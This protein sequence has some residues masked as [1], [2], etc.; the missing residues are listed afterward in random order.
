MTVP[1][2]P[3]SGKL[4]AGGDVDA[5]ARRSLLVGGG[6]QVGIGRGR[7]DDLIH[8]VGH[9]G[10]HVRHGDGARS[11]A[12]DLSIVAA[13]RSERT[14]RLNS[15]R[16]RRRQPR[17]GLRDRGLSHQTQVE[18]PARRLQALAERVFVVGAVA[19]R[20]FGADQVEIGRRRAQ[21]DI[22]LDGDEASAPGPNLLLGLPDPRSIGKIVYRLFHLKV[23]HDGRTVG[24]RELGVRGPRRIFLPGQVLDVA[25]T[26]HHVSLVDARTTGL[27]RPV[28][29][30]EPAPFARPATWDWSRKRWPWPRRACPPAP[31][32][33]RTAPRRAR[34]QD[35]HGHVRASGS[36]RPQPG[37]AS[38]A[39]KGAEVGASRDRPWRRQ[40]FGIGRSTSIA[41]AWHRSIVA[42]LGTLFMAQRL[43]RIE[44]RCAPGRVESEHDSDGDAEADRQK[45]GLQ[46]EDERPFG[47]GG[48]RRRTRRCRARC[49]ST[50]PMPDKRDR[51]DQE[52]R[53]D[54][55][56]TRAHGHADAD[57]PVRS[58]TET[59]M[60]FMMPM[61]P[62]ISEI[63]AIAAT[64]SAS[65][66]A[67]D[68]LI[69]STSAMFLMVMSSSRVA[70]SRGRSR[71]NARMSA[72]ACRRLHPSSTL[73]RM[74]SMRSG[75][76]E[77]TPSRRLARRAQRHDDN[78][79]LVS[80]GVGRPLRLQHA[81]HGVRDLLQPDH[82]ADRIRVAEQDAGDGRSEQHQLGA[83]IDFVGIEVSAGRE[84]PVAC[85]EKVARD[86]V[87]AGRP[88]DAA[89]AG[90][91]AAPQDRSRQRDARDLTPNASSRRSRRAISC[92][93]H[94]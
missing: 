47:E 16:R 93:G 4:L 9:A 76:T 51:L 57:L 66:P 20:S 48:D 31:E 25:A 35:R 60:M 6:N 44:Q 30:H 87:D 42:G 3:N 55:A 36:R 10:R 1:W 41:R 77:F 27:A 14:F 53:Q 11:V 49:R 54:V 68:S 65:A 63:D 23:Q 38:A 88:I 24:R 84:R 64:S 90:S 85:L 39:R 79:V 12:D 7:R 46:T 81:D 19:E 69:R 21:Q 86:A 34:G 74:V 56:A 80:S 73:T 22:L 5:L 62:T 72:S 32:Q 94:R 45:H 82:G 58:T 29:R 26:R 71:N 13:C 43:D 91:Q 70:A 28:R 40:D 18:L 61:P 59:S 75:L 52:L 2:T 89:V 78:I 92:F 15:L 8:A 83:G 17:L 67:E 33:R 50:P 37:S